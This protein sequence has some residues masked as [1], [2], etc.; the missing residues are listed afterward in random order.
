M[1]SDK[2][3]TRMRVYPKDMILF[4]FERE[5]IIQAISRQCFVFGLKLDHGNVLLQLS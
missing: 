2:K 3:N 4:L 1:V 5:M